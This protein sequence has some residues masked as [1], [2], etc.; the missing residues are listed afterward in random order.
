MPTRKI[1]YHGW[2]SRRRQSIERGAS[3]KRTS[4]QTY[5]VSKRFNRKSF[6]AALFFSRQRNEQKLNFDHFS[7]MTTVF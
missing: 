1:T 5:Q 3:T 6:V 4:H 2:R 7:D